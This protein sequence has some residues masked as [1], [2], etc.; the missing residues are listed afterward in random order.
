MNVFSYNE[1]EVVQ[2]SKFRHLSHPVQTRLEFVS[3]SRTYGLKRQKQAMH[4]HM[5]GLFLGQQNK[6]L[7][8]SDD[9]VLFRSGLLDQPFVFA[10]L[11]FFVGI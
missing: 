9:A 3:S 7:P 1:L 11:S 2:V 5:Y 6:L 10:F 4:L 8:L